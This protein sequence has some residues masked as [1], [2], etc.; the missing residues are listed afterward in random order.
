MAL[1]RTATVQAGAPAILETDAGLW[2][3]DTQSYPANWTEAERWVWDQARQGKVA[4]FNALRDQHLDPRQAAGWSADRRLR[5]SFLETVLLEEPYCQAL[6]R[7]RLNIRGAW[8]DEPVDL[9]NATLAHEVRLEGCRFEKAV[10]LSRIKTAYLLSFESSTLVEEVDLSFAL[11]EGILSFHGTQCAEVTLRHA[12]LR[13]TVE[14]AGASCSGIVNMN[15]TRIDGHLFMNAAQGQQPRFAE[16]SLIGAKAAGIY[17]D[18]ARCIG[19]L[20]MSGCSTDRLDLQATDEFRSEFKLVDIARAEVG[21]IDLSGAH[22]AGKLVLNSCTVRGPL[23]MSA[24]GKFR[25]EFR[26]I[27]AAYLKVAAAIKLWGVICH[28]TLNLYGARIAGDLDIRSVDDSPARLKAINL[29]Q[30]QVG[31]ETNFVGTHF[32]EAL[33][34]YGFSGHDVNLRSTVRRSPPI[35][36]QV[37]GRVDLCFADIKGTLDLRGAQFGD[38][39]DLTGARIQNELK[40]GLGEGNFAPPRWAETRR[41]ILRGASANAVATPPD[42]NSWPSLDLRGFS[43]VRLVGF[44]ESRSVLSMKALTAWLG[45]DLHYSPQPYEQMA[46]VLRNMGNAA[47]A[48]TVLY[49]GKERERQEIGWRQGWR[50]ADWWLRDFWRW[51]GLSLLRYTIGYGFGYRYFYSLVWVAVL[52]IAGSLVL[53][54]TSIPEENGYSLGKTI[55]FSLDT[56]LP[57]IEFEKAFSEVVVQGLQAYYFYFHKLLGFVLGGFI[58]AGLSGI[59]KK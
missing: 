40:L 50:R 46:S 34:M 43:Y 58:V 25:S 47:A 11:V 45:K 19:A 53:L 22:C 56:L 32:D 42:I 29:T 36:S 44:H 54:S 57:I 41:L 26:E 28:G 2:P 14:F 38:D 20:A 12:R 31:G 9:E 51:L 13:S 1:E 49:K 33:S 23:F 10:T 21:S 6:P 5:S 7:Q 4:D 24:T 17:L 48:N 8:F 27:D 16:I 15:S 35:P 59:T 37:P 39:V 55:A 52:T 18:G 3:P 30:A